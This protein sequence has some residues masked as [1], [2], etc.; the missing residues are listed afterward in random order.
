MARVET[1]SGTRTEH[2]SYRVGKGKV[3]A[4]EQRDEGAFRFVVMVMSREIGEGQLEPPRPLEVLALP[5][6]DRPAASRTKG[7]RPR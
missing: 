2:E 4:F 1:A 6:K 3:V 7:D 5:G